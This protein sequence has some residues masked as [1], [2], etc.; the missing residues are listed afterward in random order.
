MILVFFC[1]YIIYSEVCL[2]FMCKQSFSKQ[3][4]A[5]PAGRKRR[6]RRVE[7]EEGD[8]GKATIA[9]EAAHLKLSY[10]LLLS[11]QLLLHLCGGHDQ[12]VNFEL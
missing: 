2:D 9:T 8:P 6:R 1:E 4:Q 12:L 7:E 3:C 11:H 5:Q 10:P